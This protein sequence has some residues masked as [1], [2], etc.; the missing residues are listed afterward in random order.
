MGFIYRIKN[1][2]NHKIYI[3]MTTEE[4]ADRR[5][6]QHKTR[7]RNSS[8]CNSRLQADFDQYGEQSFDTCI[9]YTGNPE[10]TK[11]DL[12]R[13]EIIFIQLYGSCNPK[14]GYNIH[15]GGNG[16][17]DPTG[18]TAEKV[19]NTLKK[20]YTNNPE[21]AAHLRS[22]QTGEQNKDKEQW[23]KLPEVREYWRDKRNG[24]GGNKHP[25]HRKISQKFN[26]SR[27]IAQNM[28]RTLQ[29]EG[30][31]SITVN[32]EEIYK[33]WANPENARQAK[34]KHPGIAVLAKEFN[35]SECYATSLVTKFKKL[36]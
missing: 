12:A 22:I 23:A 19:S 6:N 33:F 29:T 27:G 34:Y 14:I 28:I 20:Y 18:E 10:E 15:G 11:L 31:I 35:I 3:G 4:T 8:H 7:L 1:K 17:H 5:L 21:A 24:R 25:G 2:V 36:A 30:N 26:I 13:W 9:L 32:E 16:W